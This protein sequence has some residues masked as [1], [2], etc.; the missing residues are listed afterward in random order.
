MR[1]DGKVIEEAVETVCGCDVTPFF[2]AHVRHAAAI[3]FDRYLGLIGLQPRL[4][5]GPAV[6]NGEPERDLRVW[7]Y[8]R[9]TTLRLVI[10]NPASIWG[11]A[12][13]HS[14]DRLIS[15]NGAPLKTW[16]ELR[17]KLQ[18]LRLGD[19]VQVR[20]QR[21]QPFDAT[22]VVR[23]FERPTVRI[24]RLPNATLAQRRLAEGATF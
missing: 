18:S 14:R 4:S 5:W 6:Y 21:D 17:A 15:I 20:V 8:E 19:T 13:L 10:N 3:D 12:G 9:D 24:E 7:G 1:I 16:P 11:R 23:G 2:D 22:V